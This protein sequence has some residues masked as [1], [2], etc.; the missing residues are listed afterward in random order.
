MLSIAVTVIII[1]IVFV[2]LL[3]GES[4]LNLIFHFFNLIFN[5]KFPV[6]IM[7]CTDQDVRNCLLL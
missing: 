7:T 2:R 1:P 6:T 4:F 3:L 5:L